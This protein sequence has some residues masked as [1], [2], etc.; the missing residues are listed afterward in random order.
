MVP[1]VA[2]PLPQTCSSSIWLWPGQALY[3]GPSLNLAPHSGSVWC[4]AVGVDRPLTVLTPDGTTRDAHS[5][6]IPPRMTHP[7]RGAAG[8]RPQRRPKRLPLARFGRACRRARHRSPHRACRSPDPRRPCHDAVVA[9]TGRRCRVVRV[10]VSA[11]VP[12]RGRDEP[13]TLSAL[14][15][16]AGRRD[17]DLRGKE[18]DD[19]GG[20]LRFRQ[21]VPPR[22]PFQGHV[23]AV[24]HS[25]AG[26]GRDTADALTQAD[27][28]AGTDTRPN[29]IDSSIRSK[30]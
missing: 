22:R 27:C 24:R 18:P 10:A 21:P 23:R 9:R 20:G 19:R 25:I 2:S 17:G 15:T 13:A 29:T 14:G 1:E 6:L 12:R 11:P 3:A 7:R 8:V 28:T 5:V 26:N 30:R 4:L 16:A